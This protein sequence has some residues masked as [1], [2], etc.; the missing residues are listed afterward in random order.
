MKAA[1][2]VIA[3][4]DSNP[5]TEREEAL[6]YH[7][8]SPIRIC[9]P[10]GSPTYCSTMTTPQPT[11]QVRRNRVQKWL[12]AD[13]RVRTRGREPPEEPGHSATQLVAV[14]DEEEGEEECHGCSHEK[15]VRVHNG[16]DSRGE[17]VHVGFY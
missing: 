4:L 12:R 10:T 8:A 17:P 14:Q 6:E 5:A 11:T 13:M 2:E 16:Y 7:T 1:T 9:S 3:R 15:G